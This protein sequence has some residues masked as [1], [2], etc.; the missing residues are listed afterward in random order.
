MTLLI[1]RHGQT[2]WNLARRWQ[3]RSDIPLNATGVTQADSLALQLLAE[4]YR[5][6][7]IISS[8]LSRARQ[9]AEIM[10]RVLGLSVEVDQRLTE[11]DLGE[12]EG[13]LEAELRAEDPARYDHWRSE[14]YL[15][16]PPGG[17]SL[18]DVAERVRPLVTELKTD[19]GDLLLV[20]HQGV[21]MALKAELSGCFEPRCLE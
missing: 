21:N 9:T 11:L 19:P 2:D 6:V 14:G 17:E 12:W 3:S 10:G 1:A 18:F 15:I 4:Q 20:G 16:A 13:R 5:P 7:R 8:P